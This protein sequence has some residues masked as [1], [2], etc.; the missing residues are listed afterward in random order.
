MAGRIGVEP[1]ASL[2]SVEVCSR[3]WTIPILSG[4]VLVIIICQSVKKKSEHHSAV[5]A[6]LVVIAPVTSSG[7]ANLDSIIFRTAALFGQVLLVK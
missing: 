2:R 7:L 6:G 4:G 5:V 1:L 3:N